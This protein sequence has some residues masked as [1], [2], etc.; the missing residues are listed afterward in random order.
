MGLPAST[1]GGEVFY[2]AASDAGLPVDITTLNK[3]IEGVN[4]GLSPQQAAMEV[5]R[6]R[7]GGGLLSD[8]LRGLTP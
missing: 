4:R 3:I 7:S 8:V 6:S 1:M 2:K 5:A